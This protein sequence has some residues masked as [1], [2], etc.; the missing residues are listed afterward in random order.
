MNMQMKKKELLEKIKE[1]EYKLDA[2]NE[3][4]KIW[5]NHKNN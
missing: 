5:K 4:N 1:M 2:S 3:R